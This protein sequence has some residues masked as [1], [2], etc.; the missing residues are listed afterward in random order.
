[1][2]QPIFSHLPLM[3]C[4]YAVDKT[5]R[6][7]HGA[8]SAEQVDHASSVGIAMNVVTS[9]VRSGESP[10]HGEITRQVIHSGASARFRSPEADIVEKY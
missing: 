5:Q 4:E 9:T 6:A 1:M 7:P 3:M 8:D 2:W 10:N